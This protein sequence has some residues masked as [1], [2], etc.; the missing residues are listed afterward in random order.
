MLNP[1]RK[2]KSRT[3]SVKHPPT[4]THTPVRREDGVYRE[5]PATGGSPRGGN[6]GHFC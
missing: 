1:I 2:A 5:K 6:S 4:P 3:V